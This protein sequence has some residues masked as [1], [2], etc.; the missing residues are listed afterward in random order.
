MPMLSYV[1]CDPESVYVLEP[2][3]NGAHVF[4]IV[5]LIHSYKLE[6]LKEVTCVLKAEPPDI[7]KLYGL[8]RL[9]YERH[10][11]TYC[12]LFGNKSA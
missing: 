7:P 6:E 10:R 8:S 9:K 1:S 2:L 3:M 4:N 5:A 11:Q 12:H